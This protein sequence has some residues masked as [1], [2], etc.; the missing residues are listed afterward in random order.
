PEFEEEVF[1]MEKIGQISD[2][3]KTPFGY[4]ITQL[5]GRRKGKEKTFEDAGEMIRLKLE[6][7][8][9]NTLIERYRKE[10]NVRV[11]YDVL[12]EMKLQEDQNIE[13]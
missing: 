2:I 7:Q 6:K 10:Y 4:H 5:T 13:E 12:D 9:F 3:I 1:K 11:N 8:K